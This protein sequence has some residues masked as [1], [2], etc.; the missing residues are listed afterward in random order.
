MLLR[1]YAKQQATTPKVPGLRGPWG[2]A[3]MYELF[4]H[5]LGHPFS[6]YV[7]AFLHTDVGAFEQPFFMDLANAVSGIVR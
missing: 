3:V 2:T 6:F 1:K 4:L 7:F 5:R